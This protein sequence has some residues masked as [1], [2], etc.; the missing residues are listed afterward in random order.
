MAS[1]D[2]HSHLVGQSNSALRRPGMHEGEIPVPGPTELLAV[3]EPSSLRESQ[4]GCVRVISFR[5]GA[6]VW[7]MVVVAM[8]VTVVTTALTEAGTWDRRL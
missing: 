8:D 5:A 4:F 7:E 2:M 6:Q 1:D 3:R